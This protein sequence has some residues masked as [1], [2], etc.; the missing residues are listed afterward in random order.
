MEDFAD[1]LRS[2]FN[3]YKNTAEYK[4]RNMLEIVLR[5]AEFE[6]NLDDMWEIYRKG[7][8]K[9]IIEYNKAVEQIKSTGLKVYRNSSG[10]HKIVVPQ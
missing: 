3:A 2:Y 8:V 7:T 1:T 9:Q 6:E 5:K 4:D 10:K